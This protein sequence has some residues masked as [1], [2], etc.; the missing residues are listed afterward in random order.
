MD[1]NRVFIIHE[2][3]VMAAKGN[4]EREVRIFR[5]GHSWKGGGAP[6][7]LSLP[8]E[9]HSSMFSPSHRHLPALII[10]DTP[11]P[12]LTPL[13][14]Q[15]YTH[16][17]A[18]FFIHVWIW[19]ILYIMHTNTHILSLSLS[20]SLSLTHTHTHT[21]LYTY[22]L[23]QSVIQRARYCSRA[24]WSGGDSWLG[25]WR[26][27]SLCDLG[28]LF[29]YPGLGLPTWTTYWLSLLPASG[30]A[31]RDSLFLRKY[32]HQS[33]TEGFSETKGDTEMINGGTEMN[34]A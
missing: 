9:P 31:G 12:P 26:S 24:E 2:R 18:L 30:E 6:P 15:M 13:T 29:T 5:A 16:T 20:L 25:T 22:E 3:G 11:S 33:C 10:Q 32:S 14:T 23:S 19:F 1:R 17:L 21:H 4:W 28:R 8:L 27:G 7:W 34:L